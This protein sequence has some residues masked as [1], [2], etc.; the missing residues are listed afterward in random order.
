MNCRTTNF[1]LDQN[2]NEHTSQTMIRDK[3]ARLYESPF[4][5]KGL[6]P[7]NV[8]L[9]KRAKMHMAAGIKRMHEKETE[10]DKNHSP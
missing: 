10:N 9:I 8:L 5:I 7:L 3:N 1:A 4:C 6:I 2:L